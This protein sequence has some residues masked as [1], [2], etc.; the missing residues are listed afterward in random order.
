MTEDEQATVVLEL[1]AGRKLCPECTRPMADVD[2]KPWDKRRWWTCIHPE[3][4]FCCVS[5]DGERCVVMSGG[6]IW[7]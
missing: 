6:D 7:P 5:D 3:C 4:S 1:L 2:A